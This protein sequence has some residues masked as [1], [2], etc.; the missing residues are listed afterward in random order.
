MRRIIL[1][2]LQNNVFQ[3]ALCFLE[4]LLIEVDHRNPKLG[5]HRG[6]FK[7]YRFLIHLDGLPQPCGGSVIPFVHIGIGLREPGIT[8]RE[9]R[10]KSDGALEHLNGRFVVPSSPAIKE[11]SSPHVEI[12]SPQV[13]RRSLCKRLLLRLRER[14]HQ[15][16]C[17]F[18]G[19]FALKIEDVFYQAIK[20]IGPKM[21]SRVNIDELRSD[22]HFVSRLP[23]A[24]FEDVIHVERLTDLACIDFFAAKRENVGPR[25][26]LQILERSVIISSVI[27]AAK[28]S[29]SFS[30][31]MFSK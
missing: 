8:G 16:P 1:G 5:F 2:I 4:S 30:E 22:A 9:V 10:V 21:K 18:L 27:P 19:D 24:P 17:N 29:L 14:D 11:F 28:Y 25:H 26:N 12:M 23:Y 6:W 13:V 31:L 3:C 7:T 20:P 15:R